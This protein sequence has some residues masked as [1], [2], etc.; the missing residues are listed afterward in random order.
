MPT[1]QDHYE[2]P[3]IPAA[4]KAAFEA[5]NEVESRYGSMQRWEDLALESQL[6]WCFV[7][8]QAVTAYRKTKETVQ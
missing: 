8:E 6:A 4:G 3:Q 7:A 1:L 2:E 5:Y